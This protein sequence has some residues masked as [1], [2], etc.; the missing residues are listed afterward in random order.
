MK[1]IFSL[2]LAAILVFSLAACSNSDEDG[3]AV[4]ESSSSLRFQAYDL[5]GNKVTSDI[6][7][8]SK[9]TVVNFWGTF[10]SPCIKEMPSLGALAKE[11]DAKDV[12]F[13]GI[14]IDVQDSDGNVE[15]SQ[16]E[17]AK[18]IISQTG[19]DYTH[20]IPSY[21][22]YDLLSDITAVPTTVFFSADGKQVGDME[23]G[24]MEKDQWVQVID[25]RLGAVS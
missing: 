2:M 7:A 23:V 16:V 25:E 19:A 9:L 3:S 4:P 12:Q 6:F 21:D 18:A 8:S 24:Y 11:Y 10:C 15:K 22:L 5:D 17:K 1:K 14:V 20:I 13:I